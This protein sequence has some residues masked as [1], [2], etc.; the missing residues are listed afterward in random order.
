MCL[1]LKNYVDS[2]FF[3]VS[4]FEIIRTVDFL[5]V[6]FWNT[7]DTFFLCIYFWNLCRQ[8]IYFCVSTL[9]QKGLHFLSVCLLLKNM[10]TLLVSICLLLK[11]YV[12]TFGVRLSIFEKNVYTFCVHLS[13]F[14]KICL[15]FWC[16]SVYFWKNV[17]TFGVC[18]STF[19]KIC[20][21]YS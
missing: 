20:L 1:L 21:T 3:C 16:P 11:K 19:E 12:Y 5:C 8:F 6:Y 17:Y 4:T 14:W 2:Y 13:T 15:R 18:L 10:F 7:C 9:F